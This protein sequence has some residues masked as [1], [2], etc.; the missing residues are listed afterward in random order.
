[1]KRANIKGNLLAG[2]LLFLGALALAGRW[3]LAPAACSADPSSQVSAQELSE[4]ISAVESSAAADAAQAQKAIEE[5]RNSQLLSYFASG[6]FT[7]LFQGCMFMGDSHAESLSSYGL[8]PVSMVAAT[9]GK[10]VN[11]NQKDVA[12]VLSAKPSVLY[13][14]YG[15]NT[16]E[17]TGGDAEKAADAYLAFMDDMQAK[18]PDTKLIVCSVPQVQPAAVQKNQT[19]AGI[20][21]MN[22][23][24]AQQCGERGIL[25]IDTNH[26]LRDEY[27]EPDHI[28][29]NKAFQK[30]WLG[31]VAQETG[32]VRP[33]AIHE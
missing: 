3:S 20:S 7:A 27:Y 28:H 25:Y 18:L 1:M 6:N 26:L 23:L 12:K 8:L 21:A 16:I 24:L 30:L 4:G 2:L 15:Q 32:R 17:R 5:Y 13:L 14:T 22:D 31:C 11:N 10:D 19:L 9:I 29:T 33:E